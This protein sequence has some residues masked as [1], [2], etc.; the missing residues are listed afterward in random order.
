[1]TQA[2]LIMH[3]TQSNGQTEFFS[4]AESGPIKQT[5]LCGRKSVMSE[6]ANP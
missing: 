4:C 2:R 3:L 5:C 6:F 1:M